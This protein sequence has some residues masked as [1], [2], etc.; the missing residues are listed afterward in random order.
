VTDRAAGLH[1]VAGLAIPIRPLNSASFAPFG[2]VITSEGIP[3]TINQGFA[4]RYNELAD[5]DVSSNGGNV[6]VSLLTAYPRAAPIAIGMMERH[7]LGS[8]LF[9][10][11]QDRP[12]SIVVCTDPYDAA[13]FHAFSATGRQGVNYKRNT[14]HFPLLV[15]DHASRFLVVDRNGVGKNLEEVQLEHRLF[16]S[17]SR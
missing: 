12:W 14:W 5:I 8:Q 3:I 7:P 2:N 9:L 1:D 13:S 15:H 16:F 4:E 11:L 6:N 17:P 10:P